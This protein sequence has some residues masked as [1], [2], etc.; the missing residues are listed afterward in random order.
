MHMIN[1]ALILLII[2]QVKGIY[3]DSDVVDCNADLSDEELS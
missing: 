3:S 2:T 1:T